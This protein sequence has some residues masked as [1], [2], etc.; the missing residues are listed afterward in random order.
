MDGDGD[1]R[2]VDHFAGSRRGGGSH[3]AAHGF[4]IGRTD[5]DMADNGRL[6]LIQ[7]TAGVAVRD[8]RH[9]IRL[10]HVAAVCQSRRDAGHL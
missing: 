6:A 3:G 1:L 5:G 4:Q 8:F 9:D 2:E 7:Q 10:K